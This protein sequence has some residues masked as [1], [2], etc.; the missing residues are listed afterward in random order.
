MTTIDLEYQRQVGFVGASERKTFKCLSVRQPF[1][2]LIVEGIKPL[3]N[4]E[5]KRLPSWE[6]QWLAIHASQKPEYC[7]KQFL[8]ESYSISDCP[9]GSILGAAFCSAIVARKDLPKA[10]RKSEWW[11]PDCNVFLIF[12]RAVKIGPIAAKGKLGFWN[13]PDIAA[14][15]IEEA[16]RG[17]T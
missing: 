15:T 6:P 10:I 4:R 9:L 2:Q 7:C 5:W 16:I 11:N 13:C 12:D 3:E 14:R 17:I 1:A 8:E